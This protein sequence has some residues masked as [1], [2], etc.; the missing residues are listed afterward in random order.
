MKRFALIG[1]L[2][3]SLLVVTACA[4]TPTYLVTMKNG[5]IFE[6]VT[7]PVVNK[8]TG[9]LEYQDEDNKKVRLKEE[10]V[11]LIKEK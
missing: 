9:Y 7:D 11:L 10:D 5:D 4:T 1:A 2:S 6:A 8:E 3:V